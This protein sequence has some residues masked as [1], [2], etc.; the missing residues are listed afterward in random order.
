DEKFDD[1][2]VAQSLCGIAFIIAQSGSVCQ[3]MRQRGGFGFSGIRDR[4][5]HKQR[6]RKTP[7]ARHV[8]R[9]FPWETLHKARLS[10]LHA[11]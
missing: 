10:A 8:Q 6:N 11:I 2:S 7:S 3:E 9:A 4:Q 5:C 1:A